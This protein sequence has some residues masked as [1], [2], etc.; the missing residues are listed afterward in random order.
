MIWTEAS[1]LLLLLHAAESR[2]AEP[3]TKLWPPSVF[4]EASPGF[5][6]WGLR[7]RVLRMRVEG[8]NG[9]ELQKPSIHLVVRVLFHMFLDYVGVVNVV[10]LG[11][12]GFGQCKYAVRVFAFSV[13]CGDS[14]SA[15]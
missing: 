3:A 5:R 13:L 6:D 9:L 11:F 2:A 4:E 1:D 7:V 15:V 12:V 14:R 10:R 8:C